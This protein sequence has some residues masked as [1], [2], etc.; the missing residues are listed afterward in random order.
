MPPLKK[1]KPIACF[2]FVALVVASCDNYNK[3]LKSTDYEMKFGKA[4]EFYDKKQYIKSSQLYEELI[5]VM[6]GTDKAEEVAYYH[7]WSEYHLGDFYL[8]QYYFKDYTRRY[9]DGKHAE[10]CH[11]MNA[12]CYYLTSPN[13]R[14]DQTNTKSAIK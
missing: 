10:E 6:R 13:Y 14:L 7:A 11:F 9:S 3:L 8:S 4:K 12:L 1:I 2:L 5:P